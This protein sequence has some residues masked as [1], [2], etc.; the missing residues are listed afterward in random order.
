MSLPSVVALLVAAADLP[1]DATRT[2]ISGSVSGYYYL[3]PSGEDSALFIGSVDIAK[4]HLEARYGYEDRRTA[5]AF[6]GHRFDVTLFHP[7]ELGITPIV[8]GVFGRTQGVAPGLE[9]DAKIWRLEL[10]S[11]SEWVLDG[12]TPDASFFYSWSEL[13]I[14][15]V[16]SILAGLVLQRTHLFHESRVI[17]HG[18]VVGCSLGAFTAKAYAFHPFGAD[19]FYT[20]AL[21][22]EL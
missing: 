21:E 4:T 5:S 7:L 2:P 13:V 6:V 15:P 20:F 19:R 18:A 17:E 8:G 11:E 12:S 16:S 14:R 9:I 1:P 22:A 3:V 10:S